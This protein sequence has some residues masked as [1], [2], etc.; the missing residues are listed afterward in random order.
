MRIVTWVLPLV[1]VFAPAAQ[2][3]LCKCGDAAPVHDSDEGAPSC[4]GGGGSILAV[5]TAPS[6]CDCGCSDDDGTGARSGCGC[7][8]VQPQATTDAPDGAVSGEAMPAP[9]AK[10]PVP[11]RTRTLRAFR[12]PG[13]AAPNFV[14]PLLN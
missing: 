9:V 1:M 5:T 2:A 6:P 7:S 12:T 14:A 10:S 8:L 13:Q 3:G 11:M 4:C